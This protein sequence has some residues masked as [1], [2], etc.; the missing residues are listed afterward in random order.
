MGFLPNC[1]FLTWSDSTLVQKLCRLFWITESKVRE[2]VF[3]CVCW[4]SFWFCGVTLLGTSQSG[5]CI[6]FI[7]G[8]GRAV[9]QHFLVMPTVEISHFFG[10]NIFKQFFIVLRFLYFSQRKERQ[11]G[12]D[13]LLMWSTSFLELLDGHIIFIL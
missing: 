12:N 1:L 2:V 6:F 3:V 7:F 8:S 10:N 11:A 4:F 13:V 5:A 9:I